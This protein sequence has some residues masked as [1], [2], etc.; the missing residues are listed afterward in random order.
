MT[1]FRHHNHLQSQYSTTANSWQENLT[2]RGRRTIRRRRPGPA[3]PLLVG[4]GIG[5]GV[6]V[7]RQ[8]DGS[9]E[10]KVPKTPKRYFHGRKR[11]PKEICSTQSAIAGEG[12]G[13]GAHSCFHAPSAVDRYY[14]HRG[15]GHGIRHGY[16]QAF[17]RPGLGLMAD[18]F[19][20]S[21]ECI[22]YHRNT[23]R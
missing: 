18:D 15:G 1:N 21:L 5:R 8:P 19:R 9:L 13:C 20:R 4:P 10:N 22:T 14:N 17:R 2:V 11:I 12:K 3:P 16:Q 7:A 23:D 6:L